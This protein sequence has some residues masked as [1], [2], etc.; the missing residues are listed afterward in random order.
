MK[1]IIL[2]IHLSYNIFKSLEE[3]IKTGLIKKYKKIGISIHSLEKA[4]EVEI[5][6][7]NYVVAGHICYK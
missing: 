5:L 4:K 3:N 1:N 2:N 7:A 6:G